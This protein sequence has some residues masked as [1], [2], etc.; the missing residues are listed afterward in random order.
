M[1]FDQY[2]CLKKYNNTLEILQEFYGIR[3]R[4]YQERKDFLVGMLQAEAS[5][6]EN[7]A[8]FIMEKIEGKIVIGKFFCSF[9]FLWI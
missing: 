6:L 7:Q 4:K 2:G 1:L 5:R 9:R 3:L 8:R